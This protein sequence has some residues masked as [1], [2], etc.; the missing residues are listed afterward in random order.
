MV[1]EYVENGE[2]LGERNSLCRLL[3]EFVRK[4][5]DSSILAVDCMSNN[6]ISGA[7]F[8]FGAVLRAVIFWP[9]WKDDD[10]RI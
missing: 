5:A 9:S 4:E 3:S 1:Q 7:Q 10:V 2:R 6:D 8:T